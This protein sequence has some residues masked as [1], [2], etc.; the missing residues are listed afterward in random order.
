MPS[1][2]PEQQQWIVQPLADVGLA[3]AEIESLLVR[4]AFDAV[5]DEG[6]QVLACAWDL[7]AGCPPEVRA[8][9][10][11]TLARLLTLDLSA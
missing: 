10:T 5:V 11:R 2:P 3:R 4:L 1:L 8:A 9:W 6:E 7:V